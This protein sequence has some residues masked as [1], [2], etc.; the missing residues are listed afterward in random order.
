MEFCLLNVYALCDLR[1]KQALWDSLSPMLHVLG[2]QK[3]CV[4]GDFNVRPEER[5][6]SREVYVSLN[7]SPFNQFMKIIFWL[8]FCCVGKNTLGLRVTIYL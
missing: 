8:I 1:A 4:C 2:G 5:H 7:S 6:S 3:F